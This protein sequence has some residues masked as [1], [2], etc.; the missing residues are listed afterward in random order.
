V[1]ALEQKETLR[2]EA[3]SDGVFAIAITLLVLDLKSPTAYGSGNLWNDLLD[4]WPVF[5]AFC[6][7]F[8]TILIIWM[9]HHNLFGNI[10]RTNNVFMLLN[11]MLLFCVTFLPYP[12][13]LVAEYYG[14]SGET[15]ATALYAGTFFVMACSFTAVWRYAS[16]RYRLVGKEVTAERIRTI[17]RQYLLGPT[18]YG[19]ALI[20][21]FL[22]V[23][24]SL[25]ITVALAI[26]FAVTASTSKR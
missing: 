26:F 2:V 23:V 25:L 6:N 24:V 21:A 17:N 13:S 1:D 18:V 8:V 7:T 19:F 3:F 4:Q 9:N 11:G 16:H 20:M 22:N 12:T 14:R 10:R 15:T 5:A